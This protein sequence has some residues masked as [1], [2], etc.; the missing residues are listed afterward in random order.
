MITATA[1]L[2]GKIALMM[3]IIGAM[4]M[5]LMGIGHIFHNDDLNTSEDDVL[6]RNEVDNSE[7]V[8]GEKSVFYNFLVKTEKVKDKK[9][10]PPF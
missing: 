8:V 4:V 6:L 2:I 3:L 7:D 5:I 1:I 10:K 9:D